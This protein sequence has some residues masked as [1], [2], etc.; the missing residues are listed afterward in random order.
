MKKFNYRNYLKKNPLLKEEYQLGDK[1]SSN[2]DYD[3]M[4]KMGLQVHTE[5]D[6]DDLKDLFSSFEDVN[7]HTEGSSL[8]LAIDHIEDGN[9]EDAEFFMNAFHDSIKKTMGDYGIEENIE[10]EDGDEKISYYAEKLIGMVTPGDEEGV[11]GLFDYLQDNPEEMPEDWDVEFVDEYYDEILDQAHA[12]DIEKVFKKVDYNLGL[13]PERHGVD[14]NKFPEDLTIEDTLEAAKKIAYALS[15]ETGQKAE[16]NMD[17]IEPA[18]FDID[19]NGVQFD[20]GSYNI[21]DDGTIKN[22]AMSGRVY[23]H[24]DMDVNQMYDAIKKAGDHQGGGFAKE[25]GDAVKKVYG[26]DELKSRIKEIIKSTVNEVKKDEHGNHLEPQFQKGDKVTYLGN[27]GEIT[28]VNKTASGTYT[29]SVSYDKGTGKTK[30][31]DLYNK[32][33][34]IKKA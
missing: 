3:G 33:G 34:E 8:S 27:P 15:T 13:G 22:M 21:Y 26:V 9:D 30:A 16:V 31:S 10:M 19:L 28:K 14:E 29:Y 4:L 24:I 12:L 17:T 25:Y 2:F 23:G 5:T 18:S 1:W 6:I 32:G 11:Q 7:Y 20:G